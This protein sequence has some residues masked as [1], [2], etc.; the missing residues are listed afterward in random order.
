MNKSLKI[1][2]PNC[3]QETVEWFQST[4]GNVKCSLCGHVF[5]LVMSIKPVHCGKCGRVLKWCECLDEDGNHIIKK[6]S[7]DE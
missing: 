4:E 1:P 5:D 6:S 7:N 2:C 3:G